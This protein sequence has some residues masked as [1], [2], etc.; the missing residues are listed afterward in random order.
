MCVHAGDLNG[1]VKISLICSKTKVAPL[2]TISLPRL[3]LCGPVLATGLAQKVTLALKLNILQRYFWTDSTI[4][5]SW[6]AFPYTNWNVFVANRIAKI[7]QLSNSNQCR[8]VKGQDNPAGMASRGTTAHLLI[9]VQ[10]G[11]MVQ[12]GSLIHRHG[13]TRPIYC[14]T[15]L[16]NSQNRN[17]NF[18]FVLLLIETT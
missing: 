18:R 9:R 8:H 7:Q 3:E 6:L 11:R 2:N 12:N 17:E 13:R 4:V 15:Y 14:S 5:L 1:Y 10:Y 16:K